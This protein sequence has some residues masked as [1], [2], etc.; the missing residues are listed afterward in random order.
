MD[1]G[2][3]LKGGSQLKLPRGRMIPP[4]PPPPPP[5]ETLSPLHNKGIST[6]YNIMELSKK[7][8]YQT[9]SLLTALTTFYVTL[10]FLPPALED[11]SIVN[12]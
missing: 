10:K 12:K 5:N 2:A 3:T 1:S 4:A 11:T 8:H 7:A 6:V 9:L